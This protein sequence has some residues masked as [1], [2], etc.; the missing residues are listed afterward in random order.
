MSGRLAAWVPL[1]PTVYLRRP[2]DELPFPLAEPGAVLFD[3]ARHALVAALPAAG[4]APGD[5]VLAPA[6]HHGS[7][8]EALLRA[9]L[10]PRFYDATPSLAPDAD[11]LE[12]LLGPRTRA[13]FL[14][15]YLGFPQ[16]ARA[17]R[18]WCD[19]RGLLL[20]EDAAQAWLADDG[21]AP[22]GSYG[23]LAVFCLYKTYGLPDG[24][25]VVGREGIA[26]PSQTGGGASVTL[27]RHAAW[28][29][30]R[31][32][33]AAALAARAER[34][35]AYDPAEDFACGELS[36]PAAGVTFLLRRLR[37]EAA[38]RRRAHYSLLLDELGDRVPPPFDRL[39]AGAAPF[40]FPV[41]DEQ[42]GVLLARLR[43]AR[44]HALDFWSV[45]HPTLPAD[46]YP[47]AAQRRART[48]ALPCH[49]ELGLRD[50][51]RV[52]RAVRPAR[53]PLEIDR[54]DSIDEARADWTEL[55]DRSGNLFS[56]WEWASTWW[57]LYGDG[58][59]LL[60]GRLRRRGR[61]LALL[62]LYA[63]R[64]R[65][66]R[67]ARFV[68]HGPADELGPVCGPGDRAAAARALR[69][70]VA[71]ARCG[72]LVAEHLPGR[73]GWS[74]LL[75]GGVIV[76]REVSPV[77][78]WN[79]GWQEY[80]ASRSTKMRRQ[81]RQRERRLERHGLAYRL[82]DASSL[83][84]DLDTLFAL[85]EARWGGETTPFLAHR[86]FHRAFAVRAAARGWLRLWLLELDGEPAAAWYGFRFA[87]REFYYQF[88]RDPALGGLDLG[89]VLVAHSVRQALED[90]VREY[91]FLRG[92][93]AYKMR[94]AT[95]AGGVETIAVARGPLGRAALGLARAADS[96]PAAR[97]ALGAA[98]AR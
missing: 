62:P 77:L 26:P 25:A 61:T 39:P 91:R 71:D 64:D 17:W 82:A 93:D 81:L 79:G 19:E 85:H 70:A 68:G 49:Q 45:P 84:R 28:V 73:E 27:R 20:V 36:R 10:V 35:H 92:D 56:T 5:E 14:V 23:D 22:V 74:A 32:S 34:E 90:G 46:G 37:P 4:L 65:P 11:E 30:S 78:R 2:R 21:F 54:L 47:G 29:L 42:K 15:H 69:Q 18:A 95:S 52:A 72:L 13:L 83:E 3:R 97:S 89:F 12:G 98:L 43:A 38:A 86:E 94:F 67:I 60:L 6:Y 59:S 16:D 8:I 57:S 80:V 63:W 55:A 41:V 66:V 48:V 75:G 24:A 9:G 88:G 40:V 96:M 7:E 50:V 31:S 76:R 44:V 33:A 58:R 53:A 51:E 1:P 87:G